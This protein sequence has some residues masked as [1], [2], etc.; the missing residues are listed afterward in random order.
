[1]RMSEDLSWS[2]KIFS[3]DVSLEAA[4]L[5]QANWPYTSPVKPTASRERRQTRYSAREKG[6]SFSQPN[7]QDRG[8]AVPLSGQ[9]PLTVRIDESVGEESTSSRRRRG[10]GMLME[11]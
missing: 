3:V 2:S 9:E 6:T 1:M 10:S 5:R 4:L 8:A 11:L 7:G